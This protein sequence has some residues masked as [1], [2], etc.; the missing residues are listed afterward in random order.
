MEEKHRMMKRYIEQLLEDLNN[1]ENAAGYNLK[2]VFNT[3][4]GNAYEMCYDDE[5]VGIKVGELIGMEQ[6]FFPDIDYLTDIEVEKVVSALTAVYYSHGLNPIFE[7]CVSD[8]IR[9]GHLRNGINYQVFPVENQ[10]V[11]VEMCDYLPQYCPL[12]S[13][14]S[15]YN[16]HQVC[17][18][19]K[20]RA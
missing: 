11:D 15:S 3:P 2:G 9:Y 4:D 7:S 5:L 1:I 20:Q 8:R 18:E 14:C 12:Y 10:I 17:C 13:L 6:F 16:K 19:L